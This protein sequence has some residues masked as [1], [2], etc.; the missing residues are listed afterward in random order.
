[1]FIVGGVAREVFIV[2][3]VAREQ[4]LSSL[5]RP[6]M[7]EGGIGNGMH[8]IRYVVSPCCW[9]LCHVSVR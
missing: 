1:M 4:W 2:G 3:G 9:K 8:V 6:Y 5:V 7:R